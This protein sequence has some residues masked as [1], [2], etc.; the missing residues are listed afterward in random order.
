M[1]HDALL[2]VPEGVVVIRSASLFHACADVLYDLTTPC[3]ASAY[4]KDE[5]EVT[6]SLREG[7][8]ACY[9]A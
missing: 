2:A 1:E 4:K 7:T 9:V 6:R 3:G 8:L 5:I